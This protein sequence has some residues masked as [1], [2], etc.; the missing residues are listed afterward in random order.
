M[1]EIASMIDYPRE[2]YMKE[3]SDKDEV[4]GLEF[5]MKKL[6]GTIVHTR[7]NVRVIRDYSGK[8]LFYEGSFEDITDQNK[9]EKALEEAKAKYQ[10]LL[11]KQN[12]KN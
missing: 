3:L 4:T 6:D 10:M 11:E 12:E 1:N 5:Q 9:I 8:I 2:R 7:E